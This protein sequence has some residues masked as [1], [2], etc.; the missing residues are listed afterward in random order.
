MKLYS[1]NRRGKEWGPYEIASHVRG[2]GPEIIIDCKEDEKI[3]LGA[4]AGNMQTGF[5]PERGCDDCCLR[6]D[7]RG[8]V[9]HIIGNGHSY[10]P[11]HRPHDLPR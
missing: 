7:G 1:Q 9:W 10:I 4:S 3:C 5:D 2:F 8:H 6:C 11:S